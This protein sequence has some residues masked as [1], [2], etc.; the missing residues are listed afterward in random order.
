MNIKEIK[1]DFNSKPL[2]GL[3]NIGATCYMNATLQC[4]CNIDMFVNYFK[5]NERFFDIIKAD[6]NK[7][8]LCSA[9][10]LLIENLYHYKSS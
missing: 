2:I 3:E 1:K 6:I 5:Y 10:K 7:E 8:K 4:L 9:F